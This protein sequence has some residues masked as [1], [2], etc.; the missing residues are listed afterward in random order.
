MNF[1]FSLRALAARIVPRLHHL[2]HGNAAQRAAICTGRNE[3][4]S[5]N[6]QNA[7]D[8]AVREFQLD[9]CFTLDRPDRRRL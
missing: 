8:P 1:K 3:I 4:S 7:D 5:G 2:E 6:E 9:V